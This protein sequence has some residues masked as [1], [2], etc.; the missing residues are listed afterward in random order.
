M[1]VWHNEVKCI[2]WSDV[3]DKMRGVKVSASPRRATLTPLILPAFNSNQAAF[4]RN[5]KIASRMD[6]RAAGSGTRHWQRRSSLQIKYNPPLAMV[7]Y[8]A[9]FEM[10]IQQNNA[11]ILGD[12]ETRFASSQS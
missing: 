1:Y 3:A 9:D 11:I 12:C 8:Y 6:R 7:N 5:P 4:S 2:I 10:N